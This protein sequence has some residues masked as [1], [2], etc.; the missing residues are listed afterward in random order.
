MSGGKGGSQSSQVQI[1]GYMEDALRQQ[2][3]RAQAVQNMPYAPIM[4]PTMAGF[5][6]GQ[7]AGMESQAALAQ[8]MGIIPQ[9]YDVA[10]GYMPG[11]IDVGNGLTAYA[12]YPG[13]KERVISAFE[14]NP[15]L[16]RSYESLYANAPT[17]QDL[18]TA[19]AVDKAR[20]NGTLDALIASGALGDNGDPEA[21]TNGFYDM[22]YVPGFTAGFGRMANKGLPSVLGAVGDFAMGQKGYDYN[23]TTGDYEQRDYM[24]GG[25][26]GYTTV[27]QDVSEQDGRA[28]RNEED[29][30]ET[31]F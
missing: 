26:E 6:S 19:Q 28:N 27:G 31:F 9:E 29:P 4:G 17:Y 7:K 5:T 22:G 21:P 10:S 25:S 8:R 13:A 24:G 2:L 11:A 3:A 14:E 30:S 12:S 23:P 15:A 20:A 1:P 18:M 16:Q